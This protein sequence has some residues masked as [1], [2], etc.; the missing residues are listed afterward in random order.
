[1]CVHI[2]SPWFP[3]K[4]L[5]SLQNAT[6]L[7]DVL[8]VTSTVQCW[9]AVSFFDTFVLTALH[10]GNSTSRHFFGRASHIHC[11]SQYVKALFWSRNSCVDGWWMT[12][13]SNGVP[14]GCSAAGFQFETPH[15]NISTQQLHKT[16]RFGNHSV[17]FSFA[18]TPTGKAYSV[19]ILMPLHL[20]W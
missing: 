16:S 17:P 8:N 5:K 9:H 11:N 13:W 19:R 20:G 4:K 6:G 14:Q 7:I 15:N 12:A 2:F 3:A 18:T 10:K 1:M